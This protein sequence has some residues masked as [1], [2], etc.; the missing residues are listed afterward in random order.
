[1]QYFYRYPLM[2]RR[3]W[4]FSLSTLGSLL[5]L[6]IYQYRTRWSLHLYWVRRLTAIAFA[7]IV[8]RILF[9]FA[10]LCSSSMIRRRFAQRYKIS[11]NNCPEVHKIIII[12]VHL[13]LWEWWWWLYC[14]LWMSVVYRCFCGKTTLEQRIAGQCS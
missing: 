2:Q 5:A 10:I 7:R 13:R 4:S 1:M 6:G 11:A 14:D 3:H 12:I 8:P 9:N